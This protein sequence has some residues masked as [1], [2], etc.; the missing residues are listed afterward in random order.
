MGRGSAFCCCSAAAFS[1]SSFFFCSNKVLGMPELFS[2]ASNMSFHNSLEKDADS[3]S[4]KNPARSSC[5]RLGSG[6]SSESS[7]RN[8]LMAVDE[9]I[10]SSKPR[11][12]VTLCSIHWVNTG[13]LTLCRST[14][15]AKQLENLVFLRALF[16]ALESATDKVPLMD[17]MVIPEEL[18]WSEIQNSNCLA[19]VNCR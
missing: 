7:G 8:K 1:A 18:C 6:G 4:P 16:L 15:L 17:G 12:D 5:A 11:I 19:K 2:C 14:G 9:T 3:S 10:S 13:L